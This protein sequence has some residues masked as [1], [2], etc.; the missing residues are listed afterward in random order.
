MPFFLSFRLFFFLYQIF[1]FGFFLHFEAEMD[2]ESEGEVPLRKGILYLVSG[3]L[4][5]FMFSEPF[6]V[7]VVEIATI[8]KVILFQFYFVF[9]SFF[10]Q[11]FFC[12]RSF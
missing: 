3:G 10:F 4:L 11:I 8:A 9:F 12:F 6:I 7:A 2:S 5:I 1:S